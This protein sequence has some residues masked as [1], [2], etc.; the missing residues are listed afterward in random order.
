ML[1]TKIK[2]IR[3][4]ANDI[5]DLL[6]RFWN[7]GIKATERKLL[8]RRLEDIIESEKENELSFEIE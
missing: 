1:V 3:T 2:P 5:S 7:K 8:S 6:G 4:R